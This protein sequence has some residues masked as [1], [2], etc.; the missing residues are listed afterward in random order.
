MSRAPRAVPRSRTWLRVLVLLLALLVPGAHAGLSAAA[1][2]TAPAAVAGTAEHDLTDTVAPRTPTRPA[3]RAAAPL[4][5]CPLP[6]TPAPEAT[7]G[8]RT[9]VPPR[10]P[11]AP[12]APRSVV[13]R[14]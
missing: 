9:A 14:C 13:L 8:R 12:P 5:P 4:R 11:H 6:A 1:P 7:G 10:A 2:L 3:P